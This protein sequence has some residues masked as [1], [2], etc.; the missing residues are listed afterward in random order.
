MAGVQKQQK[1]QSFLVPLRLAFSNE[2]G[3]AEF[4]ENSDTDCEGASNGAGRRKPISFSA[5]LLNVGQSRKKG[6]T[7]TRNLRAVITI[8][9]TTH[10]QAKH[11]KA[12]LQTRNQN[13]YRCIV[14]QVH[15]SLPGHQCSNP[16]TCA[17]EAKHVPINLDGRHCNSNIDENQQGE[18]DALVDELSTH[19]EE[20]GRHENQIVIGIHGIDGLSTNLTGM[21]QFFQYYKSL[22]ITL[23]LFV[24][25]TRCTLYDMEKFVQAIDDVRKRRTVAFGNRHEDLVRDMAKAALKR[26]EDAYTVRHNQMHHQ[27]DRRGVDPKFPCDQCTM[28]FLSPGM[29]NDHLRRHRETN[30]V[31]QFVGDAGLI[32]EEYAK[33]GLGFHLLEDV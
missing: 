27:I 18:L 21:R 3:E 31:F 22:P 32:D 15:G 13:M 25:A 7:T 11:D 10:R 33:Y 26:E 9:R 6:N 2:D 1:Q 12:H 24:D 29:L 8:S 20:P 4:R 23:A 30:Q 17:A 28:V 19:L 16:H 14:E 5:S